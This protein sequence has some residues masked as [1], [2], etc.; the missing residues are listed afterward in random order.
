MHSDYSMCR[1]ARAGEYEWVREYQ[2]DANLRDSAINPTYL[3]QFEEG[4][5]TYLDLNTRLRC[6]KRARTSQIS[7][8]RA[9]FP[10][11]SRVRF[12]LLGLDQ[13]LCI[14]LAAFHSPDPLQL[15]VKQEHFS[16]PNQST[17]L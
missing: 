14:S 17:D 7:D 11:P 10:R 2:F 16:I 15:G 9:E 8:P 4:R 12:H 3:L 1:E 5:C 6:S 13:C